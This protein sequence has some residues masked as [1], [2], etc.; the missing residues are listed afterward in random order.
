MK[1]AGVL[2]LAVVMFA[3]VGCD[4]GGGGSP[5][6]PTV[7]TLAG[8]YPLAEVRVHYNRTGVDATFTPPAITGFLNLNPDG[9]FNLEVSVPSEGIVEG[10]S[11]IYGVDG[12]QITLVAQAETPSHGTISSDLRQIE[13]IE[14]DPHGRGTFV[15]VFRR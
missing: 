9:T 1:K 12:S 6:A 3:L 5:T 2:F 7:S 13:F 10:G 14:A 4:S 15:L 8:N 11:G